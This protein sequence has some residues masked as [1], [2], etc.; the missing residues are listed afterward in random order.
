[1][2][3]PPP[4]KTQQTDIHFPDGIRTHNPSKQEAVDPRIAPRGHWDRY[5]VVIPQFTALL[6]NNML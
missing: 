5:G 2:Q 6:E 4:D 1:M 3:K